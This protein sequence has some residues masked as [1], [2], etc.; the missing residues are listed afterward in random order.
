MPQKIQPNYSKKYNHPIKL[1]RQNRLA[2]SK[3]VNGRED[4]IRTHGEVTLTQPFQDCT[5][6]RSDTSLWVSSYSI[7]LKEFQIANIS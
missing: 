4:G 1:Q 7:L 3:S 5:L 2:H 6:S